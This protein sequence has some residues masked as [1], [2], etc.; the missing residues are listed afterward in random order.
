M[1]ESDP[2]RLFRLI[3]DDA[4]GPDPAVPS[5]PDASDPDGDV[6][7][8]YSRAVV[9]A[10]QRAGPA[11]I[12]VEAVHGS[13]GQR[14]RSQRGGAGSGFVFTPDGF[15]LTNSHV[16]HRARRVRVVLQDG[17]TARADLVGEDPDTDVALLRV[18]AADL[19]T[20]EL[21]DSGRLRVGQLVIAIGN[22]LGFQSTVTAGVVSAVGRSLRAATGRLIEDVV[23]TDA[24]L[25]PGNSGGPLVD[26]RGRVVGMNT[27]VILPAQ[28]I[29]FA[30]G[31]NTVQTVAGELL[32]IGRVR[33]ARLG[34]TGQT[35]P[36]HP[37]EQRRSL[38]QDTGV[39]ILSI[40]PGGPADEADLLPGDVIVRLG[41]AP[42]RGV[43]DLHRHLLRDRVGI[44]LPLTV[45]RGGVERL[46]VRATPAED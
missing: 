14:P 5:S 34:I 42:V 11:V 33:R 17:R 24:A 35:V 41:G 20:V 46:E 29:C 27:A 13:G 6:W 3:S 30:V 12:S 18:D 1:R 22:P 37:A 26:A 43:D 8:A 16:V 23:Q 38:R 36:I 45:L 21:G 25:N 31:I 2:E 39:V 32:R 44:A 15:A 9:S 7:D 40:V 19:P 4:A 10:A 28:G